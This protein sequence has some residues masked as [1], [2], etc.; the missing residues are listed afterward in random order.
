ML[1]KGEMEAEICTGLRK[2]EQEYMGRG[3]KDI[4]AHLLGDLVVVRM[5]GV[6]TAAEKQMVKLIPSDKGRDL[7]KQV[8]THLI[9]NARPAMEAMIEHATGVK[10]QSLHHD[11]STVTGEE[12]ILFT[13]VQLPPFRDAK[14]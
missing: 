12:V 13:L 3:P 10:V 6:L 11:I 1:T 8:R 2:F 9:E 14:R 7:L 5:T 4:H